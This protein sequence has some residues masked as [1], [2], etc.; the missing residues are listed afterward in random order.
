LT[1]EIVS[2]LEQSF[3]TDDR[4]A[5]VEELMLQ[6]M[7]DWKDRYEERLETVWQQR[8]EAQA[9]AEKAFKGFGAAKSRI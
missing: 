5:K 9:T 1:G 8:K 4:V 7:E 6:R 3:Q 2:R